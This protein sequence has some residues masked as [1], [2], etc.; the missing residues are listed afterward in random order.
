MIISKGNKHKEETS[1][2]L[3]MIN[4]HISKRM[5]IIKERITNA[6]GSVLD[7]LIMAR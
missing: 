1:K 5:E 3:K 7:R 4:I 2:H 6:H